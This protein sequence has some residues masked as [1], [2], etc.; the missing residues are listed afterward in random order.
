MENKFIEYSMKI[1]PYIS[2]VLMFYVNYIFFI[3]DRPR[4]IDI[5]WWNNLFFALFSWII[6][7]IFHFMRE[8]IK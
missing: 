6:I 4:L 1:M 2:L 5:S 7:M 8:D 3:M